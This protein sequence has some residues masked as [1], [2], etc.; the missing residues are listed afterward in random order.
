MRT[1]G[2]IHKQELEFTAWRDLS[3]ENYGTEPFGGTINC[4][5]KGTKGSMGE[6]HWARDTRERCE[7]FSFC[8]REHSLFND[9]HDTFFL[10]AA[11]KR[12]YAAAFSFIHPSIT[13]EGERVG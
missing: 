11:G 7:S 13:K 12:T 6:P 9:T 5:A 3:F 10:E 8:E 4:I 1:N 2:K